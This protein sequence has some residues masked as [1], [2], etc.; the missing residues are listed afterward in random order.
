MAI[1]YGSNNVTTSGIFSATSGIFTTAISGTLLNIDNL[2]LDGNSITST[3]AGTGIII[4]P[5]GSGPL[6]GSS[7]GNSRG[8]YSIDFQR[9]RASGAQVASGNRCTILNGKN[10][11]CAGFYNTIVNGYENHIL[12]SDQGY[13][14]VH[15]RDNIVSSTNSSSTIYNTVYGFENTLTASNYSANR[16]NFIH[17]VNNTVTYSNYYPGGANIVAGGGNS[18][19]DG[20]CNAVFGGSIYYKNT[21]GNILTGSSDYNIVAGQLHTITSADFCAVFGKGNTVDSF[22]YSA[23]CAGNSNTINS[24]RGVVFG[25]NNTVSANYSSIIG[26]YQNTISSSATHSSIIG[27]QRANATLYGEICHAAGYFAAAGDAQH[28]VYTLRGKTSGAV[29]GLTELNLDGSSTKL[30]VAQ[31]YLLSGTVNI[32]GCKSDGSAVA[33]YLRQVT[34]KRVGTTT[35]LVSADTIGT[36]VVNGT[37]ISITADDTNDYLSIRTS[38]VNNET[39]RWVATVD[40]IRMAYGT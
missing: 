22:S 38:G 29:A 27:G 31:G 33:R 25:S 37:A 24:S 26:G 30:S 20:I 35:T 12:G 17:G 4:E 7:G 16:Y 40:C 6:L 19:T 34:I 28:S 11:T 14:Q 39:W 2:R 18:V 15:G 5:S 9:V 10:N 8:Q 23:I 36:D 3:V 32:L 21:Y 13:T 1:D